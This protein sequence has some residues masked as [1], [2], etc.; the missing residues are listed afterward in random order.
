MAEKPDEPKKFQVKVPW[1]PIVALVLL[2]GGFI[3]WGYLPTSQEGSQPNEALQDSEASQ[4]TSSLGDLLAPLQAALEPALQALNP[5]T[6][7]RRVPLGNMLFALATLAFIVL[8][9]LP[10]AIRSGELLNIDENIQVVSSEGFT[11]KGT[12]TL[13]LQEDPSPEAT[14]RR[15]RAQA[16]EAG[17]RALAGAVRQLVTNLSAK[18][19]VLQI[20]STL[21][22]EMERI[23]N[24]P[25]GWAAQLGELQSTAGFNVV[26]VLVNL[27]FDSLTGE[28]QRILTAFARGKSLRSLMEGYAGGDPLTPEMA[29][30]AAF[31]GLAASGGQST[32][33]SLE[34]GGTS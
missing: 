5:N 21:Q 29:K 33:V 14:Y 30:L 11:I 3:V 32:M 19:S 10:R 1:G 34:N 4:S 8:A 18:V 9:L 27:D 13:V 26:R 23:G 17:K 20:V 25:E 22:T 15:S 12:V 16:L 6:T 31:A 28:E 7:G 24:N 2:V